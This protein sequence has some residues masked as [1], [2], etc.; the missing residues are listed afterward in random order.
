M[1]LRSFIE[2]KPDSHFPIQNL[3]Y[4]VFSLRSG[5]EA[6]NPRVGVAI[7]DMVLDLSVIEDSGLF[8]GRQ[9]RGRKLFSRQSLN[10]FMALGRPAW[11]EARATIQDLLSGDNPTLRDNDALRGFALVPMSEVQMHLPAEIGDYTDFSSSRGHATTVGIMFRGKDNAL[12]P[13]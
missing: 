4:G 9:L 11:T 2:V 7:G 6:N 1:A 12:M 3:P 5:L 10:M 8:N 13:N